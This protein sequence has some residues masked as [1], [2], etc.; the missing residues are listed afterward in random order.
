MA[1]LKVRENVLMLVEVHQKF[2]PIL[3]A[4]RKLI[5]CIAVDKLSDKK[6]SCQV[7]KLLK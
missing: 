5:S 2:S 4:V 6:T 3:R 1:Y 7:S